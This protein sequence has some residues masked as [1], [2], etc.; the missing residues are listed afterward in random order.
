MVR[1]AQFAFYVVAVVGNVLCLLFA[2]G[3]GGAL[4]TFCFTI[5]TSEAHDNNLQV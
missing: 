4:M 5:N 2:V 1:F 3:E